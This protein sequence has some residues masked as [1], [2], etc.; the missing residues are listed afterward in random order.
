ML[1]SSIEGEPFSMRDSLESRVLVSS[2]EDEPLSSCVLASSFE[3]EPFSLHDSPES[4]VLVSLVEDKP[5]LDSM[6]TEFPAC[7]LV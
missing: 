6:Q 5:L 7:F 4:C 3:G 1:A 2:V